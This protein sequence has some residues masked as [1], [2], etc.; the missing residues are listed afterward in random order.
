MGS[1]ASQDAGASEGIGYTK[2][3]EVLLGLKLDLLSLNK[4]QE[5]FTKSIRGHIYSMNSGVNN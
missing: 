3:E 4:S 2:E 1:N 5:A